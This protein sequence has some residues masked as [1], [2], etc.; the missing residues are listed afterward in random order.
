MDNIT[1]EPLPLRVKDIRGMKFGRLTVIAIAGKC[2]RDTRW[3]CRCECGTEVFS[4]K[5][6]MESGNTT[7]CGCAHRDAIR[8]H[9]CTQHPMYSRWLSMRDRCLNPKSPRYNRYGGRGITICERWLGREGF[10][11]YLKDVGL[12]PTDGHSLDRINND[13]NYEPRNVRWATRTEQAMNK[14]SNRVLILNGVSKP[15]TQWARERGLKPAC[16]NSRLLLGWSV[17]KAITTP[18]DPKFRNYSVQVIPSTATD[19][20][21]SAPRPP[22]KPSSTASAS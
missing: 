6:R 22:P 19:T 15:L 9:N 18:S 3:L 20:G 5:H 4:V 2:R 10:S 12:P 16:V 21:F 17:E 8:T 1:S 11:N 13:G 14:S 7:S